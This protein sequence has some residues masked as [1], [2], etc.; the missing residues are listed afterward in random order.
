MNLDSNG[1]QTPSIDCMLETHVYTI[2]KWTWKIMI[3]IIIVIVVIIIIEINIVIASSQPSNLNTTNSPTKIGDFEVF[4]IIPFL[5]SQG[6]NKKHH[7]SCSVSGRILWLQ[8]ISGTKKEFERILV[9]VTGISKSYHTACILWGIFPR[10]PPKQRCL[11]KNHDSITS[12]SHSSHTSLSAPGSTPALELRRLL[13]PMCNADCTW[14]DDDDDDDGGMDAAM[15]F[16]FFFYHL[17][18]LG[19]G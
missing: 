16:C 11:Q 6:N 18:F 8:V 19:C 14:L 17:K 12:S 5:E 1:L 15:F 13:T 4:A 3:T 2:I 10:N 9:T 7:Q